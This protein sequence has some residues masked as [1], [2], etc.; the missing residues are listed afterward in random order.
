MRARA[1]GCVRVSLTCALLGKLARTMPGSSLLCMAVAETI[2]AED[3]AEMLCRAFSLALWSW[4]DGGSALVQGLNHVTTCCRQENNYSLSSSVKVCEKVIVQN[5]NTTSTDTCRLGH[6]YIMLFLLN[7]RVANLEKRARAG[8]I[9]K[10]P[11]RKKKNLPLPPGLPQS[12]S[13]QSPSLQSPS[14]TRERRASVSLRSAL[15]RTAVTRQ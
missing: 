8:A 11:N 2:W 12:P 13:L 4:D 15:W 7:A 6:A 1:R 10:V 9:L 3:M 5:T 14:P